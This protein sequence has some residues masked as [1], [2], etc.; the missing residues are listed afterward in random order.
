M[1][2]LLA[3]KPAQNSRSRFARDIGN[4]GSIETPDFLQSMDELHDRLR[5]YRFSCRCLFHA[6]HCVPKAPPEFLCCIGGGTPRFRPARVSYILAIR[7]IRSVL[8]TSALLSVSLPVLRRAG[9]RASRSSLRKSTLR[10]CSTLLVSGAE[11]SLS[12]TTNCFRAICAREFCSMDSRPRGQHLRSGHATSRR[13][14][15]AEA[16]AFKSI[17][18]KPCPPQAAV[19]GAVAQTKCPPCVSLG[20]CASPMR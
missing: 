13:P 20:A 19:H 10:K 4:I 3:V 9:S 17:M 18:R 12:M 2:S 7:T 15:V 16:M 5:P 11:L 1:G 8:S 14:P 6:A